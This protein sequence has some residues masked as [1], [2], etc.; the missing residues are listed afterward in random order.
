MYQ[1]IGKQTK[2]LGIVEYIPQLL[3]HFQEVQEYIPQ[4]LN[5]ITRIMEYIPQFLPKKSDLLLVPG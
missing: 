2:Y 5:N 1:L 4:L 3:Q